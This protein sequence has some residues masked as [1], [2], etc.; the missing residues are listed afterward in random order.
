MEKAAVLFFDT[1]KY[2]LVL[3]LVTSLF[4]YF[5]ILFFLPFGVDNYDPN[6]EYTTEF[7]VEMFLFVVPL[8]LTLLLNEFILRP[9]VIK[10]SMGTS[11]F[12]WT[13]WTLLLLSTL[14]FFT[15]N[16]LGNWHDFRWLSY[17][18]FLRDV[19]GVMIF[20]L[21]GVFFY[22]KYRSMQHRMEYILTSK[23]DSPFT[24]QL[25]P[26]RGAG[27]ND[28]ITLSTSNFLFGK[29]QDNYVALYYL[30]EGQ[31]KKFLIRT[32]LQ[33]LMA[34]INHKAIVRCHRSYMVNLLHVKTIKGGNREI[35][36][37]LSPLDNQVPVSQSFK[38]EVL[39]KLHGMKNFS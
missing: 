12:F 6:H 15:Y 26:F 25:I 5:F 30:E 29:A 22:F 35:N 9:L 37:Y 11:I 31:L 17:L 32:P 10:K 19:T 13:L 34:S 36:L 4:F 16:F 20:P 8:F 24:G 1:P 33:S 2:K 27:S 39:E 3:S 38:T 18:G 7:L 14:I 28:Q 21:V 23:E